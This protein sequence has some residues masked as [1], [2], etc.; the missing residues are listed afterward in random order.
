M[1]QLQ[2]YW[3]VKSEIHMNVRTKRFTAERYVMSWLM[4]FTSNVS[5]DNLMVDRG[6]GTAARIYSGHMLPSAFEGLTSNFAPF[7]QFFTTSKTSSTVQ[8]G[9]WLMLISLCLRPLIT[10]LSSSCEAAQLLDVQLLGCSWASSLNECQTQHS[11]NKCKFS[12]APLLI[13][14]TLDE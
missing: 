5:V 12:S 14:E 6:V 9:I 13:T 4:S 1:L 3:S 11:S 8:V 7:T 10:T 2:G